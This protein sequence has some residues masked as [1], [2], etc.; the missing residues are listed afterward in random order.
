MATPKNT[1]AKIRTLTVYEKT[2][3]RGSVS[4]YGPHYLVT[5]PEI[6]LT[7]RWLQQCGFRPGQQIEVTTERNKL[8]ITL[9][10][11]DNEGG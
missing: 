2:S 7:G 11:P 4:I 10:W 9:G 8:T 5:N 6:R 1:S 3:R